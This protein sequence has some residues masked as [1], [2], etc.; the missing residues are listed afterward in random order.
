MRK[1]TAAETAE[2][3]AFEEGGVTG[4]L[5]SRRPVGSYR[6]HKEDEDFRGDILVRVFIMA[7]DGQKKAWPERPQRKAQWVP[8]QRAAKMVLE[9]DLRRLIRSVPKI[10]AARVTAK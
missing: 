4:R 1:R 10:I 9:P 5:W 6:Y 2:R 3:E 7:V 8:L